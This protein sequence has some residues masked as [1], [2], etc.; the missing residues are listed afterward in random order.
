MLPDTNPSL[1]NAL[2]DP[3]SKVTPAWGSAVG[4]LVTKLISPPVVL[5]PYKVPCGPYS[6]STRSMSNNSP[7]VWIGRASATSSM[8]TPTGEA[9]FDV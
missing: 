6:T 2:N 1:L 7:C 4:R 3:Y 5:R 8:L 9:L